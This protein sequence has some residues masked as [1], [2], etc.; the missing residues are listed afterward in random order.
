MVPG[1]PRRV[2]IEQYSALSTVLN[3]KN[4]KNEAGIVTFTN[5]EFHKMDLF[6]DNFIKSGDSYFKPAVKFFD[7]CKSDTAEMGQ[8]DVIDK[9]VREFEKILAEH[10]SRD[11]RWYNDGKPSQTCPQSCTP[12]SD[13]AR[14]LTVRIKSDGKYRSAVSEML[15]FT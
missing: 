2:E 9:V 15:R 4:E 5:Q 14:S 12:T 6:M 13:R 3:A 11:A 1:P 8:L 7:I 10:R